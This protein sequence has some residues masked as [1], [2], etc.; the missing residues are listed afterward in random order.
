MLYLPSCVHLRQRAFESASK[1]CNWP[2][3]YVTGVALLTAVAYVF[4]GLHHHGGV[5]GCG[6]LASS[7]IYHVQVMAAI[8]MCVVG[9]HGVTTA[10]AA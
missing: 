2:Y 5:V 1:L 6:S 8:H 7:D 3:A 4:T 9:A 10:Q